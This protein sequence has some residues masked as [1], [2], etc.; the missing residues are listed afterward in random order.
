MTPM[1]WS[2]GKSVDDPAFALQRLVDRYEEDYGAGSAR[3]LTV[4]QLIDAQSRIGA[5]D[6]K[7]YLDIIL[8]TAAIA[9]ILNFMAYAAIDYLAAGANA[10]AVTDAN[11]YVGIL[12][13]YGVQNLPEKLG[14][15]VWFNGVEYEVTG[16]AYDFVDAAGNSLTAG[17]N[18]LT[19]QG[20]TSLASSLGLS[21]GGM[22]PSKIHLISSIIMG[23]SMGWYGVAKVWQALLYTGQGG[24]GGAGA[25]ADPEWKQKGFA[26]YQEKVAWENEQ[27]LIL[28]GQEQL[29]EQQFKEQ[30]PTYGQGILRYAVGTREAVASYLRSLGWEDNEAAMLTEQVVSGALDL[31][32][33]GTDF[34]DDASA[35]EAEDVF[36]FSDALELAMQ[37]EAPT[38]EQFKDLEP[39]VTYEDLQRSLGSRNISSDAVGGYDEGGSGDSLT[40]QTEDLPESY[41]SGRNYREGGYMSYGYGRG[42]GRW[43]PS[44]RAGYYAGIRRARGGYSRR[45]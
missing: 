13:K 32:A 44:F 38:P 30:D 1:G 21:F 5:I 37:Y 3:Y 22:T 23:L 26:S 16:V 11:Q 18:S 20:L 6:V 14:Q 12:D 36:S 7:P 40:H 25:T 31:A 19:T 41:S 4:Q 17:L 2:Y 45:Y 35:I 42:R 33:V 39:D 9:T 43:S 8:K 24:F 34:E 15:W 29:L 27:K 10:A 28:Q